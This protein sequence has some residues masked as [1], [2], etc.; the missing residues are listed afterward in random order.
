M[1]NFPDAQRKN[2]SSVDISSREVEPMAVVSTSS[3]TS[4]LTGSAP[5][6]A[7]SKSRKE[8]QPHPK[9]EC[10]VGTNDGDNQADTSIVQTSTGGATGPLCPGNTDNKSHKA[11]SDSRDSAPLQHLETSPMN[12][13]QT[14]SLPSSHEAEVKVE[15]GKGISKQLFVDI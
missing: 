8:L 2:K 12:A 10:A 5:H 7:A 3:T 11:R 1:T 13:S 14:L 4:K 6:F 9:V 15:E